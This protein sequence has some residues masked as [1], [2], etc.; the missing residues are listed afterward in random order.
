MAVAV[1]GWDAAGCGNWRRTGPSERGIKGQGHRDRRRDGA[2]GLQGLTGPIHPQPGLQLHQAQA[3]GARPCWV[4]RGM[5]SFYN[6][7]L[8]LPLPTSHCFLHDN[9]NPLFP[10]KAQ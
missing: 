3:W 4:A 10:S 2:A 8:A 7:T 6:F 1:V 9:A 5:T